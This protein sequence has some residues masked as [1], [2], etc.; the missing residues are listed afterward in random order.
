V[1]FERASNGN[2]NGNGNSNGKNS[3][4]I[5]AGRSYVTF[6]AVARQ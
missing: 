6:R 4:R 3:Y 5:Y 1:W 2:N